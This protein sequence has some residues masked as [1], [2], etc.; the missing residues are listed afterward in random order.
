MVGARSATGGREGCVLLWQQAAE[1]GVAQ[2]CEET[3]DE[4]GIDG[5]EGGRGSGLSEVTHVLDDPP[6]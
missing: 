1:G 4:D 3:N 2:G 6:L 5:S